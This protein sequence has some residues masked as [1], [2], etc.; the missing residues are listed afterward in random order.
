MK[1]FFLV[2]LFHLGISLFVFAQKDTSAGQ[3]RI[4]FQSSTIPVTDFSAT[5]SIRQELFIAPQLSYTHKSGLGISARTYFL[6]GHSS[7]HFLSTV[8]PDYEKDNDKL[9]TEV[10]YTHFFYSS[11]TNIPYSPIKNELYGNIRLKKKLLQPLLT[12]N[13]GW[14]KDS[15]ASTVFDINVLAGIAHEFSTE[16]NAASSISFL[17]AVILNAGTN[18]YF[19]LLRGSPYISSSKNYNAVIHSQS[20]GRGRGSSG[21]G[22]TSSSPATVNSFGLSQLEGNLYIYYSIGRI[23]IEPDASIFIPLRSGNS[24][25]GYFQLTTNFKL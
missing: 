11:N 14:G 16:I 22:S 6:T 4:G 21:G 25:N 19:S 20:K 9:Y 2:L 10:N 15:S 1:F 23:T 18:N 7:G 8:S 12:L 5:D 24:V 17:P 3:F 13:A